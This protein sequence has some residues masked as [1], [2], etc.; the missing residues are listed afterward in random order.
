MDGEDQAREAIGQIV[1]DI[2][3][4][5]KDRADIILP[6]LKELLNHGVGLS[7]SGAELI[8]NSLGDQL[9]PELANIIVQLTSGDLSPKLEMYASTTPSVNRVSG[10]LEEKSVSELETMLENAIR[11]GK[12]TRSLKKALLFAYCRTKNLEKTQAI[13]QVWT[14]II[15]K[16]SI[17]VL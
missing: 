15:D 16:V 17:S 12:P 9:T 13:Y 14:K 10:Q 7:N 2:L 11:D 5:A 8:Q 3:D 6:V 1:M 4:R